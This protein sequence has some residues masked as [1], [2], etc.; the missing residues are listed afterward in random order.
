MISIIHNYYNN[1]KFLNNFVR[2]NYKMIPTNKINELVNKIISKDFTIKKLNLEG[3]VKNF[4]QKNQSKQDQDKKRELNSV[5]TEFVV[6]EFAKS[7]EQNLAFLK[8][9]Y[10]T[11]NEAIKSYA[12][13]KG[14]RKDQL[15]FVYKGGNILRIIAYEVFDNL[16]GKSV[17]VLKKYYSDSFKKSDADFSIYI[18]PKLSNFSEIYEDMINLSYLLQTE[19]RK[20]FTSN[21]DKY[22]EYY[23]LNQN[24]KKQILEKYLKKLNETSVVKEKKFG[25]DTFRSLVLQNEN[26]IPKIDYELDYSKT[27][28]ENKYMVNLTSDLNEIYISANRTLKFLRGDGTYASFALVRSKVSLNGYYGDRY[29][30]VNGELIDVSIVN[31]DN[32]G[33]EHFFDNLDKNIRKF[34]IGSGDDTYIIRSYSLSYLLEDLEHILFE[35]SNYPWEDLKY[36]KRLKRILFIYFIILM[37]KNKM[38]NINRIKYFQILKVNIFDKIKNNKKEEAIKSIEKFIEMVNNDMTTRNKTI[39]QYPFYNLLKNLQKIL[40]KEYD[41]EKLNEYIDIIL[42]NIN[43]ISNVLSELENYRKNPSIDE[44]TLFDADTVN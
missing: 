28:P 24:G 36:G 3:T 2:Y 1:I 25:Y 18:D 41:E 43:T 34:A 20:I 19:I 8:V 21:M 10:G 44:E 17:Q 31:K 38:S 12:N 4:D 29:T 16:C 14:L 32:G 22:F 37:T 15:F 40:K 13:I 30:D 42:E 39:D 26:Y 33:I 27:N 23:R 6:N 11:F 9:V 5:I 35:Y 7:Q